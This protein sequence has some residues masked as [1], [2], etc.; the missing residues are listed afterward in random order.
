MNLDPDYDGLS[1]KGGGGAGHSLVVLTT[2]SFGAS[3]FKL[4][5]LLSTVKV[6][7]LFGH[8]KVKL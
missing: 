7:P 6:L 5:L 1:D 4:C 2:V 3:V 8:H